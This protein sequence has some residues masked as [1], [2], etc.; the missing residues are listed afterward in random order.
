[1]KTAADLVEG[2]LPICGF[3]KAYQTAV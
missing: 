2:L 1:M 3:Q